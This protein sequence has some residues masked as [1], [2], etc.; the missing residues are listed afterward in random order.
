MSI[1]TCFFSFNSNSRNLG[2]CLAFW[3]SCP[4]S[5]GDDLRDLE[6]LW[7][8]DLRVV[9]LREG[10]VGPIVASDAFAEV[11]RSVRNRDTI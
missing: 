9:V 10:R 7:F 4:C 2:W 5:S 1:A 11:T 3:P 6:A 8:S